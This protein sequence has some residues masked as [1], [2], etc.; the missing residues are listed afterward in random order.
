[1]LAIYPIKQTNPRK[2]T[3]TLK[4]LHMLAIYPIKQTN[5]RKG[6]ETALPRQVDTFNFYGLNK[7]IPARGRKLDSFGLV[8]TFQW[9]LNKQIP[10]RGRKLIMPWLFKKAVMA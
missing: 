8:H 9:Q 3:E 6:T 10:A 7:Q 4:I 5:P 2:G 1:M